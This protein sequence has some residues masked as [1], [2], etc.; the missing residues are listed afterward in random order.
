MR[1]HP[2]LRAEIF[3]LKAQDNHSARDQV[4][5]CEYFHLIPST[6][7]YRIHEGSS[8]GVEYRSIGLHHVRVM[9]VT[10]ICVCVRSMHGEN[11]LLDIRVALGYSRCACLTLI[12]PLGS[13]VPALFEQA[14]AIY[15]A[16][17]S[18]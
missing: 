14:V 15:L 10:H 2:T 5:A 4:R 9:H 12:P 3:L 16:D 13:D 8:S 1:V 18:R 6:F 11:I 17:H 7:G